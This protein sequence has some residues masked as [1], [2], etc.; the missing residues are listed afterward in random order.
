MT[1]VS[2]RS[3]APAGRRRRAPLPQLAAQ[4]YPDVD[5]AIVTESTYPF[6]TGGLSAVVHDIV[7][8]N[9]DLSFGI[10]HITWDRDS[11]QR[12]ST[13]CRTTCAG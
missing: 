4:R 10:I 9:Q 6:L 11:P 7:K 5:V 3:Q 1:Y 13:G 12:T 2:R 8:G